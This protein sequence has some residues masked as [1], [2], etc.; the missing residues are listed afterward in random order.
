MGEFTSI[1]LKSI[2]AFMV[3]DDLQFIK[4]IVIVF[5]ILGIFS[6]LKDLVRGRRSRSV[7]LLKQIRKQQQSDYEKMQNQIE[8]ELIL[9]EDTEP[10]LKTKPAKKVE[11]GYFKKNDAYVRL[12]GMIDENMTY[13]KVC[14]LLGMQGVLQAKVGIKSNYI[15]Y[16]GDRDKEEY[17][18]SKVEKAKSNIVFVFSF[19]FL[20]PPI[21]ALPMGMNTFIISAIVSIIIM[22]WFSLLFDLIT[23]YLINLFLLNKNNT[24]DIFIRVSFIDGKVC[25]KEQKGLR[26]R[27]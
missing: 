5:M 2:D 6:M 1:L 21:I 4:F 12:F 10:K 25:G 8:R 19:L 24:E 15:W 14:E 23:D 26:P 18:I 16:L 27:E 17:Y 3:S 13:D 20:I 9:L 11:P 22:L 7:K